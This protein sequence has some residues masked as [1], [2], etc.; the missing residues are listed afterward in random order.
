MMLGVHPQCPLAF[1]ISP[2]PR[3]GSKFIRRRALEL[4]VKARRFFAGNISEQRRAVAHHHRPGVVL[5]VRF[6]NQANR[7]RVTVFRSDLFRKLPPL[8]LRNALKSSLIVLPPGRYEV[9]A[10]G[11]RNDFARALFPKQVSK[12][13]HTH[14]ITPLNGLE[15]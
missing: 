4:T 5:V 9:F 6:R 14:I 8:R 3:V 13:S 15:K 1:G 7:Q 11:C 12:K 10:R 2:Q